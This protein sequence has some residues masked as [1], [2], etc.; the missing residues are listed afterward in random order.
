MKN[1]HLFILFI[2]TLNCFS[3]AITVDTNTYTV[4]Q[5]VNNVL[6]NSPCIN[7]T[8]I[9]WST[10]TNFGST[11]GIGYFQS[12][13]P[14][15]PM[16]SGVILSTGN[17]QLAP[18][19]NTTMQS[20]G[21]AAW[22][23]DA[24]LEA[25]LA[26]SGIM[27]T[28][29]NAT[30]LQFD[31]VPLSPHFDFDFLFASEEYGN[32]QCQFSDAFAFLLTNLNTGVTTN[33]AVVPGSNSP[34]SVVTIRDF[35]YNS[36]CPSVNQQYFGSY[37]GGSNA[38]SAAI[39][40]NGQTKVLNASANLV[41]NVPYEIK[42][43]IAD[44]G[45]YQSDSAIFLSSNSFNIGQDVLGPD[46]TVASNTAICSG[47]T[48]LINSGLD[49]S[50]YTFVWKK[51]GAII[52][53]QNGP[54]LTVS[55]P[56]NY[57]LSYTNIAF[58]CQNITDSVIVEYLPNFTTANPRDLYKCNTSQSSYS[59]DLSVNT[60]LI[61]TGVNPPYTIS[62]F[63][64]LADANNNINAIP[65]T[66]SSAGNQTIY[67]RINNPN[68]SCYLVKSF[69]LKLA[70]SPFANQP[71]TYTQCANDVVTGIATFTL[72]SLNAQ[73]LAGQNIG[74]YNVTYYTTL[75]DANAGTNPLPNNFDSTG[76]T[77]YPKVRLIDDSTCFSVT[78]ALLNVSPLPLVDHLDDV[79]TCTD[80]ILQP[81]NNGNYFT[82][83][84][85][86]GTPLFAGDVI[87]VTTTIYIFNIT[88]TTP[89]CPN[90]TNFRVIIIKPSEFSISSGVYCNSYA[91]PTMQFGEY[92]TA[93]NGGGTVIPNGTVLTTSQ[94][95]YY[96]FQSLVPPFCVIDLSFD[97][98]IV[99]SQEVVTFTNQFDCNTFILQP[100]SFG[101]YFDEPNGTG[102][103]IPAGTNINSSTTM[104]IHGAVGTCVSDSQFQIV[105]GLNFPTDVTEC[106]Q[107][108]LPQLVVGNYY[109]GPMGTGTQI[110]AGTAITSSQTIYVY[111]VSQSQP[112]CTDNYHFQVTIKLPFLTPPAV[113]TGCE[114]YTLPPLNA[115]N[116]YTQAGGTGTML[117][118]NDILTTSQ[119]VYIYIN[120][121]NGCK[122]DLPFQVTINQRPVIDSRSLIDTCDQYT[123]TNLMNGNYYTGP[124]GTGTMMAGGTVL[125]TS[126]LVYIFASDNGCTAETSFQLNI[127]SIS[128]QQMPNVSKCDSYILPSLTGNNKY[129]TQSGGPNGT[130]SE[131]PVG[132]IMTSSQTVFIY[133]ESGGRINCSNQSSFL[134]TII[135]TPVV[136]PFPNVFTCESYTLPQ[137]TVGNYYTQPNK[138]G[139]QLNAGSVIT[140]NQTLYI[141]AETG[142]TPNCFDEKSF[143]ITLYNVDQLSNVTTCDTYILPTLSVGNY[144]N[145]PNGT[146]GMLTAGSII[147]SSKMIYIFG[148]SGYN[149]NCTD[150]TLFTVTIIPKPFANTVPIILTTVCDSDSTNDGITNFNLV[151][152]SSTVLGNQIGSEFSVSYFGNFNDANSNINAIT[153]TT[154]AIVYVRVSNSLAPNCYDIKPISI[155]VNKLPEPILKNGIICVDSKTGTL[156]NPY[157]LTSG[158]SAT[159]YTF[160]WFNAQGQVVGTSNNYLVNTAGTYSLI[161]TSNATGCSS[162][163]VF[164]TVNQSEP[165]VVAYSINE[166]FAGDQS[167]TIQAT[168][169]GGDYEYQLDNLPFQ[170]SAIFNNVVSGIHVITVR[171][172]N[173][174]GATTTEA[175]VVNY[176]HYF[177]PNGDGIND[178]WNIV[179][180]AHQQIANI[181]IFDRYGKILK[182]IKP[183]G[184]GWDGIYNNQLMISDD[185]WFSITYIKNGES[186]EFKAHFALKR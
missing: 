10:G 113:T 90:E 101:N 29:A 75:A 40:F 35:L 135:P 76:T 72:N 118:P 149:P 100:L 98:Q 142:S 179:D 80:Y 28:S 6:I 138:A 17:V 146:G 23:G 25:T 125:T 92:R 131:I 69:Q 124:N 164:A 151:P 24:S 1:Y 62:Y 46:L 31:F 111:A 104:Y 82:G 74:I 32:Y 173:G 122:N 121:N 126:Q 120:D 83:S 49:P 71:A 175:I 144:Y 47:Q 150:E 16:Q 60:T 89:S 169:T 93:P 130:G 141:Y 103:Q 39:N 102:N 42:L 171:D 165:A 64:T 123:L 168:G 26:V 84:N 148:N 136:A 37:N 139:T 116:Y 129:Y 132:T 145:G 107:Y 36:N 11:N 184:Q 2:G 15:F 33:L 48:T 38:S 85:G 106:V 170:D 95:V 186:K 162:A 180:L 79:I 158:L 21:N 7:A 97:I 27:M 160:Q 52:S 152:L 91:L 65:T 153:T 34:I 87:S 167:V 9:T 54:I 166:D 20:S 140:T 50:M 161:A 61:N 154:N 177:T 159:S 156:L 178:T 41:P 114:N 59:Y 88:N 51:D 115:G 45:D 182:N 96:Y 137:L 94:T 128:A 127:F 147:S 4:P 66:F 44:R 63:T 56:G 5:L 57:Q 77:V 3:Q 13:N 108:V 22:T 70:T 185:Y 99:Q 112:N 109:T 18:G 172:K 134:V 8:N 174:C 119:T 43:V 78:T 105:V 12:N 58:N 157:L 163:Q 133:V 55:Q 183:S 14:N 117:Q 19:P 30:V 176:P 181:Y 143:S 81:L 53:G 86:T 110:P 155:F 68:T 67:V 73:V